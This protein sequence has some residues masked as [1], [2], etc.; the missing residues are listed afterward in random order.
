LQKRPIIWSILLTVAT[1]YRADLWKLLRNERR[2]SARGSTCAEHQIAV[3][4]R[5]LLTRKVLTCGLAGMCSHM[6]SSHLD[7]QEC[8][9]MWGPHIWVRGNLLTYQVLTFKL[10]GMCSLMRPHMWTRRN[11][12]RIWYNHQHLGF[13]RSLS[14]PLNEEIR[15]WDQNTA[16]TYGSCKYFNAELLPWY[17]VATISRLLK[18][19]GFFCRI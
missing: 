6:K 5:N 1:P 17:G 16:W 4:Q 7:L 10:A 12:A 18:S 14:V 2:E 3:Y 11:C 15:D 8:A 19:I 9:H 13:R